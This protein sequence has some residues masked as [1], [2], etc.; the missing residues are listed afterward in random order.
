MRLLVTALVLCLVTGCAGPDAL[1]R[2]KHEFP[3]P[4]PAKA[5]D[6]DYATRRGFVVMRGGIGY[7]FDF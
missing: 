6:G 5:P 7:R 3:P 1:R 4:V 2:E